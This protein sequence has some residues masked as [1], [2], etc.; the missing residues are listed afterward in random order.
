MPHRWKPNVT[1]AAIIERVVEGR[2]EFLLVEEETSDGLRLNNP[3]GH[4]DPGET[5][6]QGAEREALEETARRFTP[7]SLVGIYLSRVRRPANGD[8]V[9]YLRVAFG[10]H[11]AEPD[12]RRALDAGIVR[13]L[14]M[15]LAEVRASRDRHR[16]PLVLRC[17]E[18]RVAGRRFPLDAVH[19]DPSVFAAE[20]DKQADP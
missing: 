4:L 7:D 8:D 18:D 16:S 10:G 12:P 11:A 1:V 6:Q 2:Q 17:I 20:A 5:P 13:T 15:S 9:T 3:A 19:S 14:W